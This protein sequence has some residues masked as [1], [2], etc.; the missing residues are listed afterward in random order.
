MYT[1]IT[2]GMLSVIV[3]QAN[4]GTFYCVPS[5][6][7]G[8]EKFDFV[9]G[10]LRL[11]YYNTIDCTDDPTGS[12]IWDQTLGQFVSGRAGVDESRSGLQQKSEELSSKITMKYIGVA[13]VVLLIFVLM[14]ISS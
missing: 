9:L 6:Q 3:W 1:R 2:F 4:S 10:T 11:K 12:K 5:A 13:A 8:Y 7:G 14:F